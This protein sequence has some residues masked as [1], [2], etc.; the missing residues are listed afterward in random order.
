MQQVPSCSRELWGQHQ[1]PS[2][3]QQYQQQMEMA[4]LTDGQQQTQLL[5]VV[6]GPGELGAAVDMRCCNRCLL[7][8]P[9]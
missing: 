3:Q 5:E 1:H 6:Q 8:L 4:L 9:C 7:C 2:Q